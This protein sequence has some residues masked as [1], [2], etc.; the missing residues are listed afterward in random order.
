MKAVLSKLGLEYE[1]EMYA[2]KMGYEAK[3]IEPVVQVIEDS[4]QSLFGK[5]TPVPTGL[6]ASIWTDTNIYNEMGI[7]ACKFGLGGGRGKF[8]SEQ[9]A[10]EDI[11]AAPRSMRWR[12]WKSVTEITRVNCG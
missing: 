9:L 8:R 2:S 11:F 7:R 6:H 5:K 3:G 4:Y 10:V 12:C 1:R